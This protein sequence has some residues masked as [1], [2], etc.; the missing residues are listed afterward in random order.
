MMPRWLARALARV[1]PEEMADEVIGDL[2]E[3]HRRRVL[4]RGSLLGTAWTLVDGAAA[5]A[6]Y[7]LGRMGRWIRDA[8][9]TSVSGV[10]LRLAL[11]LLLKQPV[12]TLTSVV[13]LGLGIG[14][15]S[16]GASVFRQVL[17]SDLPFPGGERW[18]LVETRDG[19]T[20]RRSSLELGRLRAFRQG[21]PAL[22]YVAGVSSSNF[23]L[24]FA[25]GEVERV[26]GSWVTPGVFRYLPY[27]PALGRLLTPE[28]GPDD[29]AYPALIRESLWERRFSGSPDVL[30]R[31]LDL[32]G[33]EVRV[34]G[35]LG[36]EATYPSEGEVWIALDEQD[37]GAVH[38]RD[39][40]GSRQIAIL[41]PGATPDEAESQLSQL[42]DALA[43]PGR[44][45]SRQRHKVT[46]F[47]DIFAD[48]SV[49]V[50]AGGVVAAMVAL[51]LVIAANVANLIMARTSQRSAE[52][53]VRAAL[54]ASRGRLVAQLSVEALTLGL[55]AAVPGLLLA[56]AILRL[57]DRVLDE[58]PFWMSL[59]LDEQT[60]IVALGLALLVSAVLGIVPALKAT[61]VR[62]GGTLVGGEPRS[63]LAVGRVGGAM[64][65]VQV[66]LS[67][68][69]LGFGAQFARGFQAYVTP[70]FDLPDDEVLVA[71]VVLDL[72]AAGNAEEGSRTAGDSARVL[73]R[74]LLERFARLPGVERVAVGSHLP[75]LSPYPE[76]IRL[77]GS[78]EILHVP[79]VYQDGELF[80]VLD[81]EPVA[82]RGITAADLEEGGAPVVVVNQAFALTHYGTTQA[83]GRRLRLVPHEGGG[84]EET[85]REIVG[86]VPNVM[87]VA[88]TAQAAGLY[89]PLTP[90]RSYYAALRVR[91]DPRPLVQPLRRGAFGVD[92]HID[93]PEV[94]ML[95]GIGAE[96]RTALGAM[97]S[98]TVTLG[99][100]T[101]LLSLA[102][103]YSIVSLAVS[104]RT[105]EIGVR[106]ALGAE[107]RSIL[108]SILRR[109]GILVCAGGIVGAAAGMQLS[110]VRLFV[111]VVP[112]GGTA[113]FAGLVGLMMLA[114]VLAC[115]LPARRALSIQPVEAMRCD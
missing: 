33:R 80:S 43:A 87:E 74:S 11:R 29:G 35:V 57:Y 22:E 18:V 107:P 20:G 9:W 7:G 50:V 8:A 53:S 23:N 82:G 104:R 113:L 15:A 69:M 48:P 60:V 30:G 83:L 66:A 71:R 114:A 109:S 37:H 77:E 64:I 112:E 108:W 59:A 39:G 51:L 88:G 115:W 110:K 96:N 19:E 40:V 72:P 86:V 25:D 81:V 24:R 42:S 98:A 1:V 97:S 12:M 94:V 70:V 79:M 63:G 46:R 91:G 16:G 38:D 103:I 111:F 89:L 21:A 27:V 17:Y 10:E 106:V 85:W 14:I 105:R 4:Q 34:V 78:E 73:T 62:G 75:R 41:A 68:A 26:E 84:D 67:V 13:A 49:Q 54:G 93:I 5:L 101:L 52:L 61:G 76:P 45:L 28:D 102:G 65:V 31:V 36:N 44:G 6:R 3:L 100:V 92:P 99:L 58:M 90:R 95:P 56:G 32:S 47:T 2:E 55:L